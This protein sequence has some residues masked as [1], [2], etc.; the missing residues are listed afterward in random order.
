MLRNVLS[1]LSP[2]CIYSICYRYCE[3]ALL[4]YGRARVIEGQHSVGSEGLEISLALPSPAPRAYEE[5]PGSM[6]H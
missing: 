2:A 5:H 3:W 6:E 1:L 4:G